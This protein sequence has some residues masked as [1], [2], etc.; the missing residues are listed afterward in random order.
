MAPTYRKD[1]DISTFAQLAERVRK[2]EVM[3]QT[4]VYKPNEW[5]NKETLVG[6][7]AQLV[8]AQSNW[9]TADFFETGPWPQYVFDRQGRHCLDLLMTEGYG[10][11]YVAQQWTGLLLYCNAV[12]QPSRVAPG[13]L[14]AG[15]SRFMPPLLTANPVS[16]MSIGNPPAVNWNWWDT[17]TGNTS[18]MVWTGLPKPQSGEWHYGDAGIQP[19]GSGMPPMPNSG[20]LVIADRHPYREGGFYV[21]HGGRGG[22]IFYTGSTSQ[23]WCTIAEHPT[24]FPCYGPGATPPEPAL[25]GFNPGGARMDGTYITDCPENPRGSETDGGSTTGAW[26]FAPCEDLYLSGPPVLWTGQGYIDST[27]GNQGPRSWEGLYSMIEA[28]LPYFPGVEAWVEA[29]QNGAQKQSRWHNLATHGRSQGKVFAQVKD[30]EVV[31]RGRLRVLTVDHLREGLLHF[32]SRQVPAPAMQGD[33]YNIAGMLDN[34]RTVILN[35]QHW[36]GDESGFQWYIYIG[37]GP[38]IEDFVHADENYD[39]Y[40]TFDGI[41]WPTDVTL[42]YDKITVGS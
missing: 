20:G 26:I 40:I 9:R 38:A 37:S 25:N 10:S 33:R 21:D 41:R 1:D 3:R 30:R 18:W 35:V 17:F 5:R 11:A 27:E 14:T 28:A 29:R 7:V 24:C 36:P 15:P 4:T 22:A 42:Y 12:Q 2:I 31:L 19:G 8:F 23:I 32:D 39:V 16:T 6:T 34:G 13:P